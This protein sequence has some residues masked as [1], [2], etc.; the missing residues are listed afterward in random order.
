MSSSSSRYIH[1]VDGLRAVAVL[2]VLLYHL[3]IDWIPGGFLGVD[4]FFVISGY[5]IT[6]LILDSI[7]RSGTLDL[8]AFYLSRIRRL[9][10]ALIAM[11]VF[12]TLFIGVYAPETVRRF[13]ADI[14]YVLT[15]SM[16]WALV[17]R[18]QDYFEANVDLHYYNIPGHLLLKL[19]SI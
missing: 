17:A 18:Q 19:S 10:P 15:G 16:N 5:V 4:L 2:A 12:T 8:R 14:P 7:A 6:G 9:L 11:L 3:G 1:S 13:V